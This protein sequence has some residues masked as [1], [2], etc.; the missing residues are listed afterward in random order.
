MGVLPAFAVSFVGHRQRLFHPAQR[1]CRRRGGK[2]HRRRFPQRPRPD[3]FVVRNFHPKFRFEGRRSWRD[4]PTQWRLHLA[5]RPRHRRRLRK[6]PRSDFLKVVTSKP[7]R[8]Y[9][10]ERISEMKHHHTKCGNGTRSKLPGKCD[11]HT[12]KEKYKKETKKRESL[13]KILLK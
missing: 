7:C 11:R 12:L 5:R 10:K 3:F 9:Q 8:I 1:C 6:Q 2:H 13:V 4:G